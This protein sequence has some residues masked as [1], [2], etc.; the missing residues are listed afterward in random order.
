MRTRVF[1]YLR[2]KLLFIRSKLQFSY[3]FVETFPM[4][5]G[6]QNTFY[7]C[8]GANIRQDITNLYEKMKRKEV[9]YHMLT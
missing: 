3:F 5:R 6:V 2:E 1:G 4:I 8:W 9:I 7:F